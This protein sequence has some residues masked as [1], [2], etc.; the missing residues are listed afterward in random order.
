MGPSAFQDPTVSGLCMRVRFASEIVYHMMQRKQSSF[1]RWPIS[2]DTL[3]S[4]VADVV[5]VAV[6]E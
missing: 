2:E 6:R 1:L 4:D 3:S 5:A